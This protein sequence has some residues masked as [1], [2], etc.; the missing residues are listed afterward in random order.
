MA[1]INLYLLAP[2]FTWMLAIFFIAKFYVPKTK[3]LA[4]ESANQ[5]VNVNGVISDNF[6]N[7]L[8]LK[9][10]TKYND[11]NE[12][13]R[14]VVSLKDFINKSALYLRSI[15]RSETIM[16]ITSS[17]IMAIITL[18]ILF[19]WISK[20]ISSG[21]VAVVYALVFKLE[22][23]FSTL[24]DQFTALFRAYALFNTS[25]NTL[26]K[27]EKEKEG[28]HC[29][30]NIELIEFKNVSM[31]HG[32]KLVLK[33]INFKI[34]KGEKVGLVG[35]TGCGKSTILKLLL[36]LYDYESDGSILI[37]TSELDDFNTSSLRENISY[38]S[39]D[40][41]FFDDTVLYNICTS[42]E[43]LSINEI[44]H[45]MSS[46]CLQ[47]LMNEKESF[48]SLL[49]TKIGNK[50]STLSGGQLQ[51]LN[52]ARGLIKKH[53]V[54]LLDEVT[55]A[56]DPNTKSKVLENLKNFFS[57]KTVICISHSVDII[58]D[59]DKVIFIKNGSVFA[60]GKHHEL[61]ISCKEYKQHWE[62]ET[63]SLE[64]AQ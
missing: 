42:K 3:Q 5:S 7:V 30:N 15:T 27:N 46:V 13:N 32:E 35:A 36:G 55:S 8:T 20:G 19:L 11:V 49:N 23:L 61:L 6:N 51:R 63:V 1:S 26:I 56:L 21:E 9:L 58:N 62:N 59:M 60:E 38:V 17:L 29:L 50:G 57:N 25:L 28:Y 37:N 54:L 45:V 4:R 53:N 43:N 14:I 52:I 47:D 24:M 18:M 10:F 48:T 64:D 16:I 44:E 41:N 39:Q 31:K 33:E 2:I 40:A 34:K 22:G 12:S